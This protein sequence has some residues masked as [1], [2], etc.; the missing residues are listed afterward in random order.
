MSNVPLV[1]FETAYQSFIREARQQ[2]LWKTT[3]EY[4]DGITYLGVDL[5]VSGFSLAY[6]TVACGADNSLCYVIPVWRVFG[7]LQG[8][9][10]VGVREST[11]DESGTAPETDSL[12]MMINAI[13]GTVLYANDGSANR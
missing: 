8:A 1:P 10:P 5:S 7:R 11:S 13:D 4:N 9:M 3:V 12:L 6:T 2:N